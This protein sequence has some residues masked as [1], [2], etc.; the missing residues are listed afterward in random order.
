MGIADGNRGV[1][2]V[3]DEDELVAR[4]IDEDLVWD[5]V[6]GLTTCRLDQPIAHTVPDG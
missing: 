5:D 6:S 2:L 1:M 4:D 3:T